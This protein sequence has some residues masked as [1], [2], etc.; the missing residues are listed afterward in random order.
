MKII[1]LTGASGAGKDF[2]FKK[3]L[4]ENK[5][6]KPIISVTTRPKRENETDGIEYKFIKLEELEE[7][8]N[9]EELIDLR[10][11]NSQEGIWY[12]GIT[13]DSINLDSEDIYLLITDVD[14]VINIKSYL[15]SKEINSTDIKSIFINCN[16]KERLLRTLKR[17][18]YLS[19]EQVLEICR[20]YSDD[21]FSVISN[22]DLF[23]IVL[24]NETIEDLEVCLKVINSLIERSVTD[25][26]SN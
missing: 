13:K 3:L 26:D 11:Y 14:G 24:K 10:Q 22:K 1:T 4:N 18:T 5:N 6:I 19:D 25:N 23:D 20:R 7:L 9:S 21:Y 2:L 17:E 16:G 12:Y 8:Y 15:K